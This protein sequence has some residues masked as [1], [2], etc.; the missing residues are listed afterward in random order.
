MA[1]DGGVPIRGCG[2]VCCGGLAGERVRGD[3]VRLVVSTGR[4]CLG[5]CLGDALP[6]SA[7]VGI[8]LCARACLTASTSNGAT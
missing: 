1:G 5:V 4:V 6:P 7:I 2:S 3:A 8:M